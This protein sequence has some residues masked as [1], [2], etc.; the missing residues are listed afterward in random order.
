MRTANILAVMSSQIRSSIVDASQ[1]PDLVRQYQVFA[2]PKVVIN[3]HWSFE[4]NLPPI[5]FIANIEQAVR[6]TRDSDT[7]GAGD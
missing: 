6:Q 3:E 4:G 2:V 5:Q 1:F 7:G